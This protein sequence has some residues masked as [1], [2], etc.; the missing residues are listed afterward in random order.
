LTLSNLI[1]WYSDLVKSVSNGIQVNAI[2]TDIK[3]AFDTV[4]NNILIYKLR[5]IGGQWLNY[6]VG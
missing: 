1:I 2:Y 3:K 6:F 4:D 5:V